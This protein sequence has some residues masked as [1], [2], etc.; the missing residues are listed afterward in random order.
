[1]SSISLA[2]DTALQGLITNQTAA[3]TTAQNIANMNNT[4]Y[5]RQVADI[6]ATTPLDVDNLQ[7]GTG[8]YISDIERIRDVYL[9]RQ[10]WTELQNQGM[11]S[12]INSTMQS[13]EV[14]FPE[15][16]N[17]SASGINSQLTAFWNAWSTLAANPGSAADK[18]A[19]YSTALSLSQLIQQTYTSL[20]GLQY[21]LNQQVSDT[22]DTI[23]SD[24]NQIASLNKQIITIKN[25]GQQP[26]DLLD[27]MDGVINNLS[28]LL[29][30]NIIN[31]PDGSFNVYLQ[32]NNLVNDGSVNQ[33]TTVTDQKN[34]R[35]YDVGLEQY[36]NATTDIT[37]DIQNGQLAGMLQSRDSEVENARL[38]LDNLAS[39]LIYAVNEFQTSSATSVP[40]FT[41]TGADSIAVN[42][43]LQNGTNI[44]ASSNQGNV[45]T[46]IANIQDK[47]LNSFVMSG[48]NLAPSGI[49]SA[50]P[51]STLLGNN[52]TGYLTLSDGTGNSLTVNYNSTMTIGTLVQ[53]I[54]AQDPTRFTAI[55]NDTNHEF[56]L[57]SDGPITMAEFDNN[58]PGN[59]LLNDLNLVETQI[60]AAPVNFTETTNS[61]LQMLYSTNMPYPFSKTPT[62]PPAPLAA[63]WLN[64]AFNLDTA[65]TDSGSINFTTNY[66]TITG[67]GIWNDNETLNQTANLLNFYGVKGSFNVNDQKFHFNMGPQ[68]VGASVVANT[69]IP[70]T[71]EDKTGNLTQVMRLTGDL[72]FG[73]AYNSLVGGLSADAANATSNL[74]EY[75]T[76]VTQLQTEQNNIKAVNEAQEEQLAQ[77]YQQAYD[78][79]T[80][81]LE[82]LDEMMDTLISM[83][84]TTTTITTDMSS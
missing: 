2:I 61:A 5:S 44:L 48:S 67:T 11:W 35:F 77:Q 20:V 25:L 42:P 26:N 57:A 18:N 47:F 71:M 64:Q 27:Q 37:Q 16:T 70:F 84:Q 31:M 7:M 14:I 3:D 38:Q 1:M 58:S 17:S 51:L 46:L 22:I 59:A 69:L 73:G 34:P 65:I 78:A 28:S 21:N 29:N 55:Y 4:N 79:S 43:A 50:T 74:N 54:N 80:K 33:L 76:A 39:S 8:S 49:T 68:T 52:D 41:G 40:F 82:I 60:S 6:A 19:V 75:N 66:G 45:A 32:G 62:P 23:N 63:T 83:G 9:D 56:F 53:A 81:V 12:V 15:I 72:T 36:T 13:L 24:L 30:V 10:I